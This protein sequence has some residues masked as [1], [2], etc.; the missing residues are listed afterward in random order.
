M[1]RVDLAA[2]A[3]V[4]TAGRL[5]EQQNRD[6]TCQPLGQ[7]DLLLVATGERLDELVESL[8][9]EPSL[10]DDLPNRRLG[11]AT[12]EPS[13]PPAE[14][15]EVGQ[16]GVLQHG[17]REHEAGALAVLGHQGHASVDRGDRIPATHDPTG[18]E[19]L[20]R[21]GPDTEDALEELTAACAAEPA[22]AHDLAS[23]DAQTRRRTTLH[24][25]VADLERRLGGRLGQLLGREQLRHIVRAMIGRSLCVRGADRKG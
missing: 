16:H 3:D 6:V 22:D 25:Q 7:D 21:A 14:P 15:C 19:D 23:P 5:V 11:L 13:E 10:L 17:L 2:G 9:L 20:A 18:H 1:I 4:D 8:G 12:L 24:A